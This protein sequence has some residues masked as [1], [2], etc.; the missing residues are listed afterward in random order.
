MGKRL[1]D[2][3]GAMDKRFEDLKDYIKSEFKLVDERIDRL[4]SSLA[5]K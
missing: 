5:R 2:L 1:D 3:T 4:E